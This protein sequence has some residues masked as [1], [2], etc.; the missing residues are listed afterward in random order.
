MLGSGA[1]EFDY[2]RTTSALKCDLLVRGVAKES[3]F[4]A[5]LRMTT[6]IFRVLLDERGARCSTETMDRAA[7]L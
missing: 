1:A 6:Q 2:L 5:S 4:F 3:G 7:V